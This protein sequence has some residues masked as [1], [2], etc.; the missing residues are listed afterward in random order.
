MDESYSAR[1]KSFDGPVCNGGDQCSSRYGDDPG[2][3][4]TARY[5]PFNRRHATCGAD[6]DDSAGD[7][8]GRADRN[9]APGGTDEADGA[10]CFRAKA[11]DGPKRR[12]SL[13]HCADDSP[14]AGERTQAYGRMGH[15]NNP[16][17]N[18]EGLDIT[19]GEQHAG[20]DAHGFLGVVGSMAKTE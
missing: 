18:I 8:V 14:A 13:A 10:R 6:A 16:K 17:R 2:P 12:Y 11:S 1:R 15:Q 20:D 3:N 7:R 9:S 5:S 19:G 4:D